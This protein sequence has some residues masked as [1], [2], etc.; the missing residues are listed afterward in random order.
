MA[1]SRNSFSF[2]LS[3]SPLRRS[4]ATHQTRHGRHAVQL[5]APDG[6]AAGMNPT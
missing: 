5:A 3:S 6:Y 1:S 4:L 2:L